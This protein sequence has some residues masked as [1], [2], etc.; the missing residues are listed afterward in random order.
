MAGVY[1][2]QKTLGKVIVLLSVTLLGSMGS[3]E[4]RWTIESMTGKTPTYF[5]P[6]CYTAALLAKGYLKTMSFTGTQAIHFYVDNF[7]EKHEGTPQPGDLL[8]LIDNNEYGKKVPY[9]DHVA[10]YVGE[11]KIFEKESGD[12]QYGQVYPQ[13]NPSFQTKPMSESYW[14]KNYTNENRYLTTYRCIDAKE[15]H[16]KVAKCEARANELGV[17]KIQKDFES[18]LFL[19]AP[20]YSLKSETLQATKKLAQF[21]REISKDDP[22]FDYLLAA[23]DSI[24]Y[25]YKSIRLAILAKLPNSREVEEAKNQLFEIMLKRFS[26]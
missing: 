25:D 6:S 9:F 23:A 1:M 21:M 22:C 15:V 8:I 11:G 20:A 19:Q 26:L 12:G 24:N 13:F 17:D 4:P 2:G 3:A 10:V 7:C 16:A 18:N 14:F 5:G